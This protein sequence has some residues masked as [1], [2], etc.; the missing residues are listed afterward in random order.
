M[1]LSR[2]NGPRGLT[3]HPPPPLPARNE[4]PPFFDP[5][6]VP[7]RVRSDSRAESFGTASSWLVATAQ[8]SH[9]I[10]SRTR[11]LSPA[12]RMVL[13]GRPGG[14]VRRCQPILRR[15]VRRMT[16]RAG[17]FRMWGHST[18]RSW[19]G[20]GVSRVRQSASCVGAILRLLRA[21]RLAKCLRELFRIRS[22]GALPL[23]AGRS[24]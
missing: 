22:Y 2:T 15:P 6:A 16:C 7:G 14:R 23:R 4:A 9:P 3:S 12:A 20:P 5:L 19:A 18:C 17:R 11:K 10:P 13:L 8:G 24:S 21:N 1:Q